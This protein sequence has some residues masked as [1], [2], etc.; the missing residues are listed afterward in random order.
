MFKILDLVKEAGVDKADALAAV[1]G[2][3]AML[4]GLELE[5]KPMA[6]YGSKL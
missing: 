5:V 2:T 3:E 1:R 6:V 4:S